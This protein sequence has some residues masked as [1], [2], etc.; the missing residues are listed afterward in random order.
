VFDQVT[1]AVGDTRAEFRRYL[2]D[3][4]AFCATA[5]KMLRDQDF[6]ISIRPR[7]SLIIS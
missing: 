4:P 2:T 1:G 7:K 3:S 6:P 5:G